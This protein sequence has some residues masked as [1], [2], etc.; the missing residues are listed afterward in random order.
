MTAFVAGDGCCPAG[1]NLTVDSDCSATC[2]NGVVEAGETCD[3]VNCP[4]DCNDGNACT[5]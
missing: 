1:C 5:K 3:G 4:T 2:G